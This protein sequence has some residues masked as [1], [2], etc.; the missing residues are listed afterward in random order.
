LQTYFYCLFAKRSRFVLDRAHASF[1]SPHYDYYL[2]L[3]PLCLVALMLVHH[4]NLGQKLGS[5]SFRF[6]ADGVLKQSETEGIYVYP[7]CI[8]LSYM[9]SICMYRERES[10]TA[11]GRSLVPSR[12]GLRRTVSS[13]SQRRKVY[14]Y[15][16]YMYIYPVDT[17]YL[18]I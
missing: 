12:F 14:I 18:Y 3:F 4:Y 11:W 5:K 6:A 2:L 9:Y 10:T 16:I 7:I 1:Y 13:N 15:K 8:C 17:W